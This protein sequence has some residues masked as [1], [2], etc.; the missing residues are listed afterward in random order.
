MFMDIT[1]H[2]TFTFAHFYAV[3]VMLRLPI[4]IFEESGI[5][6]SKNLYSR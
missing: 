2:K 4:K 6:D 3:C 1:R 5:W